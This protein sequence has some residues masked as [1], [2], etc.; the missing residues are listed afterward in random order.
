MVAP[1]LFVLDYETLE[2]T[3]RTLGKKTHA[4]ASINGIRRRDT[5]E[6][7]AFSLTDDEVRRIAELAI[8]VAG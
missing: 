1:D 6:P 5:T 3:D 2:I 4:F 7:A 8:R